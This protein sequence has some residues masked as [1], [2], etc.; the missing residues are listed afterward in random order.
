MTDQSYSYC[1]LYLAL[2][3][4]QYYASRLFIL[5]SP[6]TVQSDTEV[7]LHVTSVTLGG[8]HG[9]NLLQEVVQIP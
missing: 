4:R 1:G 6:A 5:I 2:F 8:F 3:V 7:L 9:P